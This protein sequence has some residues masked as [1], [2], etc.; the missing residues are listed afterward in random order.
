MEE[1]LI[2]YISARSRCGGPS[3]ESVAQYP[4]QCTS[5]VANQ[6][7]Q[8]VG[9]WVGLQCNVPCG[10][11]CK[12]KPYKSDSTC[13]NYR[14]TTRL[15][16]VFS[17][18]GHR[19]GNYAVC[20]QPVLKTPVHLTSMLWYIMVVMVASSFP[21]RCL[22]PE[23]PPQVPAHNNPLHRCDVVVRLEVQNEAPGSGVT[24]SAEEMPASVV[25]P[26]GLVI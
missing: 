14:G 6:P 12:K 3:L 4:A 13:L 22:V 1:D 5:F 7:L 23:S 15:V 8:Y 24:D 21:S 16:G 10:W 9:P 11:G 17:A 25:Q 26:T 18:Q 19:S 2:C 20:N